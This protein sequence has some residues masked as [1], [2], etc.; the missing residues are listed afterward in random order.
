MGKCTRHYF[1]A[2]AA[3]ASM[4]APPKREGKSPSQYRLQRASTSLN[5]SSSEKKGKFTFCLGVGAGPVHASM[6]APTSRQGNLNREAIAGALALT[7]MKA[8]PKRQGKVEMST[9][10]L[11]YGDRLNESPFQK[12]GKSTSPGARVRNVFGPQ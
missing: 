2:V 10:F 1:Y 5:E 12:E 9:R 7:S 8:P 6:K 4:K 11:R 3:C